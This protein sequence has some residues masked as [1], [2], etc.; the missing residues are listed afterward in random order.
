[1]ERKEWILTLTYPIYIVSKGRPTGKT[2]KL[3]KEDNLKF[4]VVIEMQDYAE[5]KKHMPNAMYVILPEQDKGVAYARNFALDQANIMS[6]DWIWLLDDDINV[7]YKTINNKNVRR[8]PQEALFG[9]QKIIDK[10]PNCLEASLEYQQFAWSA[11]KPYTL[12][13]RCDVVVAL[14]ICKMSSIRCSEDLRFKVDRDLTLKILNRG[15]QTL[16]IN[17]FSFAAPKNGSNKGGLYDEY[18]TDGV[19][20]AASLAMVKKW[21]GVCKFNRKKDGRPDVKINWRLFSGN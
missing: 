17:A 20:E 13:T 16:R 1:M 19:E 9:A 15:Y 2:F 11:A 6:Y 7:F 8:T 10:F 14:R 3:L 18:H 4:T 12:N 5:Y 21:P